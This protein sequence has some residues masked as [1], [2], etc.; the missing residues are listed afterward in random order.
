MARQGRAATAAPL[1]FLLFVGLAG[2]AAVPAVAQ[3]LPPSSGSNAP[4][5]GA[6]GI[7][8][9][10]LTIPQL[11]VPPS[12]SFA[13]DDTVLVGNDDDWTGQVILNAPYSVIQVTQF[14]RTEMPKMGWAETAIVRA[15]RTSISFVR[16]Q[17]VATIRISIQK[18]DTKRTDIDVVVSPIQTKLAP[19]GGGASIPLPRLK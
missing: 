4:G 2:P 11:P 14:Y 7:P 3:P 5:N 9:D 16:D 15:R 6:P 13:I 10:V 17:R 18:D 8:P 12:S 19:G 1:L